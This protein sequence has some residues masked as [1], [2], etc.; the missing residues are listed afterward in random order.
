MVVITDEGVVY[1]NRYSTPRHWLSL[2]YTWV[3]RE[4]DNH[5]WFKIVS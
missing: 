1:D 5:L 3:E 2:P 4:G